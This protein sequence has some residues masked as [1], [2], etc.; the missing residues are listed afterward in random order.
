MCAQAWENGL[1]YPQSPNW[2]G[3]QPRFQTTRG[4]ANTTGVRQMGIFTYLRSQKK[5]CLVTKGK[6]LAQFPVSEFKGHCS[7]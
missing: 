5:R 7:E 4:E 6:K 3:L 2:A 1:F